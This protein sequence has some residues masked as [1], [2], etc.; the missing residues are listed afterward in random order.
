M[1]FDSGNDADSNS[2]VLFAESDI[3]N[4]DVT[5]LDPS[6][7]PFSRSGRLAVHERNIKPIHWFVQTDSLIAK[8]EP[9]PNTTIAM[10]MFAL[11]VAMICSVSTLRLRL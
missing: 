3:E 8:M 4:G 10:A 2:N 6:V 11:I 1:I 7:T 9:I 5:Y